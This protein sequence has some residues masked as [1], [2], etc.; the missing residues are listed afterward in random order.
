VDR[1]VK[2][3]PAHAFH[4]GRRRYEPVHALQ[5]ALLALRTHQSIGDVVLLLEPEPVITSGRSA[6]GAN[7]L[8]TAEALGA[9]GVDLVDTGRGGDVTFHGPGQLVGY[10]ILDLKPDRQDLRRYVRQLAELMILVAR[11]HGVE[12]GTVDG[13]IGVWV[14]RDRP[15][16]WATAPWATTLAKIGAI[17]VR[18]SRWITMHGFA[19]NLD[20]DLGYFDLIV[21]CGIREHPVASIRSLTGSAPSVTEAA[22]TLAPRLRDALELDVE[23]VLDLSDARD[24]ELLE[25]I[26][27]VAHRAG[28]SASPGAPPLSNE[29][30]P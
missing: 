8:F 20:V 17:G 22:H 28:S 1:L 30:T 26:R 12:A 11:D 13:L 15:E 3:R 16:V 10:P 27:S 2:L 19:L 24:D 25:R 14:D 29:A 23:A 5:H 6:K 7:V 21:P 9:R 4:L 18:V